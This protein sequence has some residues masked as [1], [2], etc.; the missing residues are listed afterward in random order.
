MDRLDTPVYMGYAKLT[1]G[2][3]GTGVINFET[4][5]DTRMLITS[6]AI[7][8]QNYSSGRTFYV[9]LVDESANELN[10]YAFVGLDNQRTFLPSLGDDAKS[11]NNISSQQTYLLVGG[12]KLKI[13]GFTFAAGEYFEVYVRAYIRGRSPS[14]TTTGSTN[15][16]TLTSATG[17][18]R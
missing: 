4:P 5:N 10:R 15:S 14:I 3:G 2:S 1:H 7:H 9:R 18:I 17:L 13:E 6:V 8:T 11:S 16:P 12:D